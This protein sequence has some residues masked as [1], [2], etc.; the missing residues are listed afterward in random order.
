M[1]ADRQGPWNLMPR[2]QGEINRL[3]GSAMET[4]SSAAT[5][6]WI[7]AVDI[8]EFGDRFDVYVDL[9]GVDPAQVELT[10]QGGLLTLSGRRENPLNSDLGAQLRYQRNERSLGTFHRR[11]VLPDSVDSEKVNATGKNGVLKLTIP[12]QAVARPR[13]IQ[14]SS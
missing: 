9:P 8:Q 3:F 7:P 11:F 6:D 4:E 14:I 10:L 2:L 12:K 5:A 13:R 1:S